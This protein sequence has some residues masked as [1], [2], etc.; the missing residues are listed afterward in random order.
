MS[1]GVK[2]RTKHRIKLGLAGIGAIALAQVLIPNPFGLFAV[3]TGTVPSWM[4][5]FGMIFWMTWFSALVFGLRMINEAIKGVKYESKYCGACGKETR[6]FQIKT[7]LREGFKYKAPGLF[8]GGGTSREEYEYNIVGYK[9]R[10]EICGTEN[11]ESIPPREPTR[12]C[13]TCKKETT[14]VLKKV[15]TETETAFISLADLPSRYAKHAGDRTWACKEC[16]KDNIERS[17]L[18]G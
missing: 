5:T 13:P 17:A 11:T 14:Q 16:G 3:I 12:Y 10:C 4:V 6:Q 2:Y 9:Y 18:T 7:V 1:W 15:E 8:G